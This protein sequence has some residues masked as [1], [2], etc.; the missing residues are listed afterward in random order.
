MF[1][2]FFTFSWSIQTLMNPGFPAYSPST[3]IRPDLDTLLV[4]QIILL[5]EPKPSH[6]L[7]V[8]LSTLLHNVYVY[9]SYSF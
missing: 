2:G 9:G 7:E 3:K 6:A 1:Y 8:R 4:Q 5:A